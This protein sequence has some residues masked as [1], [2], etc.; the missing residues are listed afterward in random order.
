MSKLVS[1]RTAMWNTLALTAGALLPVSALLSGCKKPE[2]TCTDT[3]GLSADEIAARSTL[4]Y[5]DHSTDPAKICTGC[6]QFKPSQ[7]TGACG[8]C[9]IMKGP[10]H[11]EGG[12]S[13][14]AKKVS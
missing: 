7:M 8:A 5:V 11:P 2:L 3:S 14:W 4:K 10:I 12:C 1:R 13:A 6:Q 9:A